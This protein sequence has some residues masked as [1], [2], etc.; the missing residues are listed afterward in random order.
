MHY[1][2]MW[3]VLESDNISPSL[4]KLIVWFLASEQLIELL[5]NWK[6]VTNWFSTCY[7]GHE[8]GGREF[9]LGSKLARNA[10]ASE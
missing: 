1:Q 9:W 4:T 7:A 10:E 6:K 2:V 5:R 8:L 3:S